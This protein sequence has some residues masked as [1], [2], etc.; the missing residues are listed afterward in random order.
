MSAHG[1]LNP[2]ECQRRIIG[3]LG[4]NFA[5]TMVVEYDEA[6]GDLDELHFEAYVELDDAA[7]APAPSREAYNALA[8]DLGPAFRCAHSDSRLD[9]YVQQPSASDVERLKAAF[10]HQARLLAKPVWPLHVAVA[11]SALAFVALCYFASAL[12]DH[13]HGHDEWWESLFDHVFTVFIYFG[14]RLRA[15]WAR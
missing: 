7:V 2:I 15:A 12:H 14:D 9:I 11:V 5:E 6:S 13:V 4:D 3:W 10:R 1:S 8:R